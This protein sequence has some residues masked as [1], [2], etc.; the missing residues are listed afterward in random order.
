MKSKKPFDF[1]IFI[2]VLILLSLGIIMVFSASAP[3]SYNSYH[4]VYHILEKQ[5]L[6]ALIGFLG[7]FIAANVDYRKWEKLSRPLLVLSIVLLIMVRIPGIGREVKDTWRWLYIGPFQFQPS[8]VAKLAIVLFF[9]SSLSRR[10]DQ[11]NYF[12]KGVVPY[13]FLI[14]VF[15]GLL[16]LEPHLSCTII[17][18]IVASILLFSAG[19]K[20]RHF[21]FLGIPAVAG[22]ATV[23]AF[24]PY[25]R[26]RVLSFLDPWKDLQGD[27][28]QAVQSLYAIGSG[29]LFG[30]GLGRSM[31][32]FLYLPEPHNDFIFSV[33]AEELGFIGVFSVLLL[34]IILI[35]RGIKIA[36]NAP[37]TFGSLVAVGITS[38]IAVQTLLNV[39]VVTSSIPPTGVSL[40][41]F[42]YGGTSLIMFMG[43]VGIL[44]NISRYANYE[45]I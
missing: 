36:V 33:L 23:V 10:R 19:A 6:Y 9:S 7:M 16:L 31:Q 40:P 39:A 37:D 3:I 15:A 42:S 25:M 26:A 8:E 34:F 12:F 1:W 38:L 35:W 30:R 29:G 5:L 11:L 24:V 21:V 13:L 43:E 18:I 17:V 22:L 41:F 20:I 4:D 44:L 28:W 14:A 45:R 32:K 27:G 2:S